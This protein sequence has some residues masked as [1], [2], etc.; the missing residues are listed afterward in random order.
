MNL[1][2]KNAVQRLSKLL[3]IGVAAAS[4]AI[5]GGPAPAQKS[6][7]AGPLPS[8]NDGAAKQKIIKFVKEVTKEGGA[9]YVP[10]R[11]RIATFDND[12]TLWAEKP[13]YFQA[14]FVFRRVGELSKDHPEWKTTQPFKAVLEKD[15]AA[16]KKM[17]MQELA[18]LLFA[19]HSG[20]TEREFEV[21][22][23]AFLDTA[24]HPRFKVLYKQL[25]YQPMLELL[26]YLRRNDFKISICSGG[27]IEF[28][29]ALSDE[30]YGV[31]REDVIGSSLKYEFRDADPGPVIFRKP[32]IDSINDKQGKPPNIQLHIGRRPILACGN[33]DGDLQMLQY[34]DDGK[35]PAL[36]L[37]VHH[38]DAEREYDYDKGTEKAL[39][40]AEKRN[41]TVVGIK[42]D[43]KIVFPFEKK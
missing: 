30:V 24:K 42:K 35:G 11:E 22:A 34:T 12:G 15:F 13:F 25:V 33:S 2:A 14:V 23:K 3:I 41:W 39:E 20:M 8:W 27:T 9:S 6:V 31:P 26:D 43:F 21:L 29:R 17:G 19:T 7:P 37:L 4:I 10:L 38:D 36:M 32:A 1:V 5:T 28:V 16:L 18:K 40:A